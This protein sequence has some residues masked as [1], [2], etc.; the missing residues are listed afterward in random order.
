ICEIRKTILGERHPDYATSLNNLAVLYTSMGDAAKAEPLCLKTLQIVKNVLGERHPDYA[1]CLTNLAVL[2]SSMGDVLKAEPLCL[3]ALE[4]LRDVLARA[5][6]VQSE[7]QQLAMGQMLRYRLDSY[8]SF[9]LQSGQFQASAVREILRW[10]GA[11]LVRQRAMRL[12]A[13]DPAIADRFRALQQ[14]SRRLASLSRATPAGDLDNWKTQITDL[15]AEKERLEAQLSRDSSAF[16]SAM[17][18][19][20]PQQIQAAV[21]RD[22]V[23]IDYLQFTRSRPAKKKGKFDSTTSLLAVIVKHDGEP[24]LVE[25]GPVAKLSGA[26]DTSRETFGMSPQ[27]QQAGLQIRRQIWEPLLPHI[28]DANTILVSVDGVLGRLPLGALPGKAAGTYLIED[29]RLA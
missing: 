17:E 26:I 27:G 13:E 19:I 12:A 28:G 25:L 1:T 21:P 9:T 20:T 10:K 3:Q 18:E 14:V 7:R 6:L 5:A 8:V 23:L 4:I 15:T 22:A 29:H 11:T 24:Q 2:Y 16:R